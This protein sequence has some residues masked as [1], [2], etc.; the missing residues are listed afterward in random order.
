MSPDQIRAAVSLLDS[1]SAEAEEAA[2]TDLRRLDAEVVPYMLEAY[3]HF[4]KRLGRVSLVYHATPFARIRDEA[5]WL[6]LKA[7]NDRAT[8][9]RYQACGL[10]AYSLRIEAVEH[11]RPLLSHSDSKTPP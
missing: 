7:Q 2:W 9:V 3:P 11:L 5:Y 1:D 4:R 6:G 10:L 8:M